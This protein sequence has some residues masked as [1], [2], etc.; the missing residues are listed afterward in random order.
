M[1]AFAIEIADADV[2]TVI[3]ALCRVYSYNEADPQ[4]GLTPSQFA[5]RVVRNYIK[6]V[7]AA[8]AVKQAES[9]LTAARESVANIGI[10]DPAL[11]GGV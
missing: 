4:D 11:E 2:A 6:E 5:N 3:T 10:T 9:A 1:A 8:D 7:V